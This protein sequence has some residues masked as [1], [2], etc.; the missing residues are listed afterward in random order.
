[1]MPGK[2]N[3]V[4]A[5]M[6]NM[7]CFS[8]I[9]YREA[10]AWAAGAGQ[11]EL[12]VMMPLLSFTTGE[13]LKI[14]NNGIAA[15]HRKAL[16][17]IEANPDR[18]RVYLENSYGLVTALNSIIGYEK[19][20]EVVKEAARSGGSIKEVILRRGYLTAEQMERVF[21]PARLTSPGIPGVE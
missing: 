15:F 20:S 4:I 14:L 21:D 17:G 18:Y 19:A 11:L 9:G 5:E 12:N 2:V 10:A 13:Q 8:V 7:V 16:A 1:M 6:L 3:P